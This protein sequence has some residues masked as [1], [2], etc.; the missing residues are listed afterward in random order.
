MR[1]APDRETFTS[2]LESA[3]ARYRDGESRVPG[4]DDPDARQRQLTRLGNAANAAALCLLMLGRRDEAAEWFDRA[5]RRWRESFE[6]APA[7]AWGRPIGAIKA[8]LLAGDADGAAEEARWA[9][10]L[11]AAEAASP[12][13]RY[14]G[15]LALLVLG[16]DHDARHVATSLH[17]DPSFPEPVADAL[18][19]LAA[20]DDAI[21]Y[22]E[23][24]EDV[25]ESFETREAY[26]ED[27]PVADTVLVLQALAEPRDLTAELESPLLPA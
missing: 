22:I 26:L 12:I 24:V 21:G 5:A 7:D 13:G 4:T 27:V 14:A 3:T 10:E 8:R 19:M 25:L 9:L 18:R 20:G 11:G 23:A 16:R 6:G 2:L 17:D 15:A 1:P